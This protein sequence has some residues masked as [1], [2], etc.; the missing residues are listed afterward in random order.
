MRKSV[1]IVPLLIVGVLGG[2]CFGAFRGSEDKPETGSSGQEEAFGLI[3]NLE[4]EAASEARDYAIAYEAELAKLEAQGDLDSEDVELNYGGAALEPVV[5]ATPAVPSTGTFPIAF[6]AAW[7]YGDKSRI[8]SGSAVLYKVSDTAKTVAVN[9]GHGTKGGSSVKTLCHPDGTPKVTGGSTASGSVSA[10][11]VSG[12]TTMLDG[13]PEA[14][15]TLKL[16]KLVKDKLIAR[17]YNVL[18]IRDGDDVQLDNIARTV[19]ANNNADCHISLHYDST[20]NNK[21]FFYI[22]V[23][24][25]AAYR[26]M[27]PVASHYMQH[28]QLG[29]SILTGM[30]GAGAKVYGSGAMALDLTQTS[31][32]TIPSVDLEVGDRGSDHSAA[33]QSVLAE[34]IAMGLDNFF[35][36]SR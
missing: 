7:P 31:Y 11:A 26:A 24:D 33:T 21:G 28:Q 2:V 27:E 17:G 36:I 18:M 10:I 25:I 30:K 4:Q 34:G 23:P 20:E 35:G 5:E 15:V 14:V 32:S 3:D 22:G 8:N 29:E 19:L 6:N 13:T 1:I 9:A 16:A 12:G